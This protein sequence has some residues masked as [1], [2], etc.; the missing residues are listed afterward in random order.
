MGGKEAAGVVEIGRQRGHAQ[1]P[2]RLLLDGVI[3]VGPDHSQR[4]LHAADEVLGVAGVADEDAG[5]GDAQRVVGGYI[6]GRGGQAGGA[7]EHGRR[8]NG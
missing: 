7:L 3:G 2:A 1:Q 5:P 6:G 8:A 4:L